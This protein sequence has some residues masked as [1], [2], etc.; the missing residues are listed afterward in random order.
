MQGAELWVPCKLLT[1]SLLFS[2]G[3]A[4]RSFRP[5]AKHAA[6]GHRYGLRHVGPSTDERRFHPSSKSPPPE[7]MERLLL[8]QT[9]FGLTALFLLGCL[10]W[11]TAHNSVLCKCCL[12]IQC[13]LRYLSLQWVAL[14]GGS[15]GTF[16]RWS[17]VGGSTSLGKALRGLELFPTSCS[18]PLLPVCFSGWK[19]H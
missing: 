11:A 15:Y 5:R 10:V 2:S 18:L 13:C 14:F 3:Q 1:Q 6:V 19:C 4:S 16:R 8:V 7:E 9:N 17:L 12:Y